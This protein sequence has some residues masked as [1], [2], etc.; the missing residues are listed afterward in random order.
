MARSLIFVPTLV[1]PVRKNPRMGASKAP[2]LQPPKGDP[3]S[4]IT[5]ATH[6]QGASQTSKVQ[7]FGARKSKQPQPAEELVFAEALWGD[8]EPVLRGLR[9]DFKVTRRAGPYRHK[10]KLVQS[11]R[12][13]GRCRVCLESIRGR[14]ALDR[15]RLKGSIR[16]RFGVDSG[17]IRA[18]SE[19][20][21]WVIGACFLVPTLRMPMSICF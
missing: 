21:Q 20:A 4:S 3:T 9:D 5:W 14:F 12:A 19:W 16:G 11:G 17:S 1:V 10:T 7:N 13:R 18:G 15:S 2:D 8:L 6:R